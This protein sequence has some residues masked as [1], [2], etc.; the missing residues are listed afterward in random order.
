MKIN[1]KSIGMLLIAISIILLFILTFIKLDRDKQTNS[2]CSLIHENK[3]EIQECTKHDT[4]FSWLIII[5]YGVGIISLIIG[6]YLLAILSI[7]TDEQKED[8]K[9]SETKTPP[10]LD[11]EENKIYELIKNKDGSIYQTDLVNETGYSKVKMTRILDKMESKNVLERKRRG[12]T[13]IIVL[14]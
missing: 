5:A 9:Q 8:K 4:S 10:K 13:N 2:L 6:G 11:N 14:K 3:L 1:Q 12:M 7:E